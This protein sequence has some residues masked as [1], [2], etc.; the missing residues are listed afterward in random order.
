[1]FYG[2]VVAT[3]D[4]CFWRAAKTMTVLVLVVVVRRRLIVAS[5]VGSHACFEF[6]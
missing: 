1:V 6:E 2:G 3:S 5:L 4:L